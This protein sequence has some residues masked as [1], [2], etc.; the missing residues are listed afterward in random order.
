MVVLVQLDAD[1]C[2]EEERDLQVVVPRRPR[3]EAR[4]DLG[5]AVT[6]LHEVGVILGGVV[7][8]LVDP[9]QRRLD[10]AVREAAPVVGEER[11]RRVAPGERLIIKGR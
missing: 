3:L 2:A 5:H 8:A 10:P 6:E 9:I 11:E 4:H 7:H 1:D